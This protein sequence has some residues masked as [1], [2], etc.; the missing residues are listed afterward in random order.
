MNRGWSLHVLCSEDV[1]DLSLQELEARARQGAR[2]DQADSE[3]ASSHRTIHGS[4]RSK[5]CLPQNGPS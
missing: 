2:G 4:Y 3:R 5:V 1:A